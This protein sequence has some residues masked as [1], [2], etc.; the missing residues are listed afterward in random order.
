[1]TEM[2]ATF[3]AQK[4]ADTLEEHRQNINDGQLD[5]MLGDTEGALSHAISSL[6]MLVHAILDMI[7]EDNART[8]RQITADSHGVATRMGLPDDEEFL[9][10]F[11]EAEAAKA[12]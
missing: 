9:K 7:G 11:D 4:L 3:D 10:A 1:M 8:L 6:N 2:T 5:Q 12:E